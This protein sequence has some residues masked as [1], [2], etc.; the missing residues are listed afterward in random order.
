[1]EGQPSA[2]RAGFVLAGGESSRMGRDKA[3][4]AC[5][6]GTLLE[7]VAA[8][9]A[10][11]AGSATVVGGANRYRALGLPAIEDTAEGCG[12]L[13][14]ICAAL[15]ATAAPWNLVVA[16]DMPALTADFLARLLERAESCG[17]DSLI[18]VSSAGRLEPLCAAYHRDALPRLSR[19]LGRGVLALH[20]AVPG[21]R[22]VLWRVPDLAHFANLNT[23][24]DLFRHA[25]LPEGSPARSAR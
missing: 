3:L 20:D 22:T 14:G 2:R 1:M 21:P 11:A 18:P 19:A 6:S 12:P 17:G 10:A 9:V 5:G 25:A 7:Q 13:A 23:P 15:A 4:L 8:Q 16:C 24:E